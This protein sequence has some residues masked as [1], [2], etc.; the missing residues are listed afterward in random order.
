MIERGEVAWHYKLAQCL[1][2]RLR[3]RRRR[4]GLT[5]CDEHTAHAL[6]LTAPVMNDLPIIYA[7]IR[8]YCVSHQNRY[9]STYLQPPTCSLSTNPREIKT[10]LT[11][12]ITVRGRDGSIVFG[13]VAK[14]FGCS[15]F[16]S[17]KMITHELVHLV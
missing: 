2:I 1:F 11:L 9:S 10:A 15:F 13:I 3:R 8:F 14:F 5:S 16:F 4:R 7:D 6:Q 12:F 17:V